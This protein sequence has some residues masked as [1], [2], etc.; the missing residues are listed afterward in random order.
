[1]PYPRPDADAMSQHMQT[2]R[3]NA[4]QTEALLNAAAD[5]RCGV[6]SVPMWNSYELMTC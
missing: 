3:D 1:M 6:Q 5:D 4:R 2:P